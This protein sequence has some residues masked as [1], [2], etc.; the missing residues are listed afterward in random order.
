M[1]IVREFEEQAESKGYQSMTKE[2]GKYAEEYGLQLQP[3]HPDPVCVTVERDEVVP[4]DKLKTCLR[5][6]RE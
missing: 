6:L 3:N 1:K 2:A 5:K 4:G